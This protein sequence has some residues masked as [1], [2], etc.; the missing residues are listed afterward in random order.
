MAET[1][2]R[3]K[4]RRGRRRAC[5]ACTTPMQP[6]WVKKVP[7]D[8]C[9]ACRA[10]WFDRG[11]LAEALGVDGAPVMTREQPAARCPACR[12]LLWF[13][14]VDGSDVLACVD[15]AG[16]FVTE[17][18]LMRRG[19][20]PA[21]GVQGAFVCARCG[22]RFPLDEGAPMEEGLACRRCAPVT[23]TPVESASSLEELL[24][25]A[26]DFVRRWLRG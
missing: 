11:E 1:V 24:E 10:L 2:R 23:V 17:A 7:L 16:S 4:Q 15:C 13:S 8:W 19:A 18:A 6:L 3:G 9:G 25:R 26:L 12:G 22:D 5:P 21:S 14:R 20:V